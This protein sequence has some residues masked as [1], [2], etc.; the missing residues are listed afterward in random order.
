MAGEN[1]QT[2]WVGVRPTNPAENLAVT[3]SAPLTSIGVEPKTAGTIF[4][5]SEQTPLTD[6]LVAPSAGSPEFL[7]STKKRL[8]AIADL[9]APSG[10]VR[11][12]EIKSNVGIGLY[13]HDIYTVPADKL[14][15]L[16]FIQ[17]VC[18]QADPTGIQFILRRG[19]TN[20]FWYN[21]PYLGAWTAH[22]MF[23][24]VLYDEGEVVRISWAG[25]LASTD[26]LGWV[27]GHLLDKY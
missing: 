16:S 3:E 14:F 24:S 5:T 25:C 21:V 9:Q 10:L 15:N 20:Y 22:A 2:K 1:D 18:A 11:V 26:V 19:V 12:Y 7:T 6:I 27:F 17:G 4:K 8:P 13:N 23:T